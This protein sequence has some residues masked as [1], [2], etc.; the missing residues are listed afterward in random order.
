MMITKIYSNSVSSKCIITIILLILWCVAGWNYDNADYFNYVW[1]YDR[2]ISNNEVSSIMD[3]GFYLL[4][5]ISH[6]FG[7][8]FEQ[9]HI[10]FY[11]L[12]L[13]GIYFLTT[14]FSSHPILVVIFYIIT[15]FFRDIIQM[16]NLAASVPLYIGLYF[17][18]FSDLSNRKIIYSICIFI[19]STI[20][21]AFLFYFIFL[22]V[23]KKLNGKG[24]L[25]VVLSLGLL[26]RQILEGIS[27]LAILSQFEGFEEKT[28]SYLDKNVTYAWVMSFCCI[29]L[30]YWTAHICKKK[31]LGDNGFYDRIE[32]F[33][34]LLCIIYI[35]SCINMTYFRLFENCLLLYSIVYFNLLSQTRSLKCK[36]II[37]IWG[38]WFSL[39]VFW[40]SYYYKNVDIIL[41]NNYI[42]NYF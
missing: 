42:L 24:I 27:H 28:N 26:G 14:R 8:N 9:F 17:L 38:I 19:A 29:L 36:F 40:S 41:N 30:N 12:P 4:M 16:R 34:K 7:L 33:S 6:S 35:F 31:N 21:I 2:D 15:I 5:H 22:F 11:I 10:I 32:N 1:R 3:I 20:H 18:L 25:I 13:C 37:V 23:D 39:F